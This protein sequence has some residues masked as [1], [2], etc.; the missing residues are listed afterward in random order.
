MFVFGDLLFEY[1]VVV[2]FILCG[3]VLEILKVVIKFLLMRF[4][5]KCVFM[6]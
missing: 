4:G 2:E 1:I 3:Y 6:I 5:V